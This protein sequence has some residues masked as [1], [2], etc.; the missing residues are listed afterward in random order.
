V[1]N[2]AHALQ[3]TVP[4]NFSGSKSV[5]T[6]SYT[7]DLPQG[8]SEE[9]RMRQ[10]PAVFLLFSSLLVGQS[11]PPKSTSSQTARQALIEMF[12]GETPNH[13]E[14]HLPEATK[15]SLTKLGGRNYFS[16]FALLSSQIRRD[17]NQISTFD[18]GPILISAEDPRPGADNGPD[19]IE[20]TVERDDLI[21]DEDQIELALHLS[22]NGKE[23]DL[24]VIPRFTFSMGTEEN[25]WKLNEITVTVRIPLGD[26]EFLKVIED[27]QRGQ[28]EK[29]YS[30]RKG[31]FACSLSA[32]GSEYLYDPE[33]AKGSKNG[34]NFVISSCDP[35]HYKVVAEPA[36]A[37]SGERAFCSDETGEVR[38]ASDGKATTCLSSGEPVAQ[39]TGEMAIGSAMVAERESAPAAGASA[40][41]PAPAGQSP[42]TKPPVSPCSQGHSAATPADSGQR[43]TAVPA[44]AGGSGSAGPTRIRV[45]GAVTQGLLCGDMPQPIYPLEAKKAGVQGAVVLAAV[46]GVDGSVQSLKTLHSPSPLLS[47][48]AMDAVKQW[49]Y[50]PYVLKGTPVEVDTTITVNF[51]LSR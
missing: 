30:S 50:Q 29:N 49:K 37:D 51:T 18:T 35:G 4:W 3:D 40:T 33:L 12:F 31:R 42:A 47:D 27:K 5:S 19:K 7:E 44:R 25:V 14:R 43:T 38:A 36:V 21:G 23:Q 15:K 45:S 2:S 8:Y 41:V 46:I 11:A 28:N 17:G 34:Y 6:F 32:L 16:D 20:L 26:P 22:R 24:P 9:A 48:A 10:A 39:E 1:Q 13:M